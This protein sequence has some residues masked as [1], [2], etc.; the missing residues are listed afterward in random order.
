MIDIRYINPTTLQYRDA[1]TPNKEDLIEVR[2]VNEFGHEN[3]YEFRRN[4]IMF[5]GEKWDKC[6]LC[7]EE[8]QFILYL[9]LL[10]ELSAFKES[11]QDDLLHV[12]M[13]KD[14]TDHMNDDESLGEGVVVYKDDTCRLHIVLMNDEDY[15]ARIDEEIER[16][17][18]YLYQQKGIQNIH[19][20]KHIPIIWNATKKC[21]NE[22][23]NGDQCCV[24]FIYSFDPQWYDKNLKKFLENIDNY[25]NMGRI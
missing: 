5:Q 3:L 7:E 4:G 11:K 21:M 23:Y 8:K 13:L 16:D 2:F 17:K 19:V 25:E 1:K 20:R 14:L 22:C 18:T 15:L 9:I 10:N 6:P 24:R 12:K